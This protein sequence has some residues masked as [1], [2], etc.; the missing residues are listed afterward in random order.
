MTYERLGEGG[1]NYDPCQYG[2]SRLQFR[3]PKREVE[4]DY[5]SFLGSTETFGKFIET[6]FPDRVGDALDMTTLNLGCVNAG[7]DS[8]VEDPCVL[9][10]ASGAKL[11]VVQVM[12]AHML[13]NRLYAV[14]PRRNDRFLGPSDVLSTLYP[15][16]DFTDINFT[17]HLMS[18]LRDT[19][20]DRFPL[21]REELGL[22]WVRRMEVLLSR[23]A[24]RT[25]LL[26]ISERSPDDAG[27]DPK[28]PEPLFISRDMLE[29]LRPR[30]EGIVEVPVVELGDAAS[31]DYVS[32][33]LG[34]AAVRAVPGP[35]VHADAARAL[36]D[37]IVARL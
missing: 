35:E 36:T 30:V 15:E 8:F 26:W 23:L 20:A 22:S 6:P 29:Q 37:M 31:R 7:V 11:C 3:G 5:I 14:H 9:E 19:A 21:V 32:S 4:G 28:G 2:R 24:T 18:V 17:R 13:S 16:V 12:G 25:V 10:I 1:L 27:D 33:E 34:L